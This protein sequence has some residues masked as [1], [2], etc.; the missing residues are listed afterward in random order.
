MGRINDLART[1]TGVFFAATENGLY[2]STDGANWTRFTLTSA[3]GIATSFWDIEVNTTSGLIYAIS[4]STIF[5]STDQGLTWS[6]VTTSGLTGTSIRRL[7][8]APNGNIWV[9]DFSN[10]L[11]RAN[12]ATPTTFNQIST[13]SSAINDFDIGPS[14]QIAIATQ[15]NSVQVST[16]NGVSFNP[17]GAAL[18]TNA[19]T[20]SVVFNSSGVL[21][22]LASD[23]PYRTTNNGTAWTAIKNNITEGSF[24]GFMEVDPSNNL[25]LGNAG[26]GRI[27]T[28]SAANSLLASP[29]WAMAVPPVTDSMLSGL[30][31]S[32]TNWHIAFGSYAVAN[33]QDGGTNWA[34]NSTGIKAFNAGGS[35]ITPRI[36][37]SASN[38]LLMGWSGGG[39]FISID[40]GATWDLLNTPASNTN[41]VLYGFITASDNSIIGYGNGVI[42]STDNAQNWTL[43]NASP[44]HVVLTN[45]GAILYSFSSVNTNTTLQRST[46]NGANWTTLALTGLPGSFTIR[47]LIGNATTLYLLINNGIYTVNT[48]TGACTLI[49]TVP[50]SPNDLVVTGP[51]GAT[52]LAVAGNSTSVAI[53]SNGGSTWVTRSAPS[54]VTRI[55]AAD[56]NNIYGQSSTVG[57]FFVSNNAGTTWTTTQLGDATG[58]ATDAIFSSQGFAYLA[59]SNMAVQK[60]NTV[61]VAPKAPTNLMELSKGPTGSY[62]VWDDN[63]GTEESYEVEK[64]VGNNTSYALAFTLGSFQ[65]IQNKISTFVSADIGATTYVR[66]RATNDAGNSAYSNEITIAPFGNGCSPPAGDFIPNNRSWTATAV[67]DPGFTATNSGPFTSS[68]AAIT[69]T[70]NGNLTSALVSNLRLGMG[71]NGQGPNN[72]TVTLNERCGQATIVNS[73]VGTG[74]INNGNSTWNPAT[75]TLTIKWQTSFNSLAFKGTTTYVLNASDPI[76]A[77]TTLTASIYSNTEVFLSWFTSSFA[78]SYDLERSTTSGSGFALVGTINYPSTSF[79]DG[80]LTAGQTY[81]YR[82]RSKN[83]AGSSANSAEV[84]VTPTTST[85]F[86]PL[87]NAISQNFEGQQGASW[88]D[89]DN[90]GDDDIAIPAFT[91]STNEFI[92]P[93]FYQNQGNNVFVRFTP[94]SLIPENTATSRGVGI[95]DYDN[96]NDLDVIIGR[97]G[98]GTVASALLLTNNGNWNFTK[99]SLDQTAPTG[100]GVAFRGFAVSDYDQD[101]FADV[102]LGSVDGSGLSPFLPSLQ[103]KNNGGT[104]ISR[105]TTGTFATDLNSA[106]T[107]L[108]GDYDNDGD[109]DI[110]MVNRLNPPDVNKLFKNNGDG[111]FSLVTGLVFDSDPATQTRAGSWGDIDNDGDLDLFVGLTGATNRLYQNNG[112]GTFT[113]LTSSPVSEVLSATGSAFGDL[114]NDGDLDLVVT[115]FTANGIYINGGTGNFTKSTTQEIFVSPVLSNVGGAFSDFDNDGFLDFY[116]PIT[117]SATASLPNLLC[118]NTNTASPSRNWIEV[119]LKGTISNAAALGARVT[120]TTTSPARTQVR[121]VASATGYGSQ[122]SLTQHFGLGTAT[123]ASQIQVRWPNGGIQTLTNVAANQI[124]TITED[125]AGPSFTLTPANAATGV[126][127]NSTLKIVLSEAG[128][129][130]AGKNI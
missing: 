73:N 75:K 3:N 56:E 124:I 85:V 47:K 4:F 83:A 106:M 68:A 45:V 12:F 62:V 21:F 14:N 66:V 17:P 9:A 110:F 108:P 57:S 78:T 118:K 46:D 89:F 35:T 88:G 29:T 41:R 91:N 128:T 96:D 122:N 5:S 63:T 25:Y 49:T 58:Q 93:Y 87:V 54:I 22:A 6:V 123:T 24:F 39:F 125:L 7:K 97:S 126:A 20:Y 95:F 101:G 117:S 40:D 119:K 31:L 8:I 23:G 104:S 43:Q 82:I 33:T 10:V 15:N 98:A 72:V 67:A 61:I 129:P 42:R 70:L 19:T 76:P 36:F 111:S 99:T 109:Q 16:N 38:R 34:Q 127:L 51:S 37:R 52:L 71:I 94:T 26:F 121:E 32:A 18:A 13:F 120:V 53:S 86:R 30:F 65:A 69:A 11:F 64:S 112:N 84:S 28:V 116:L 107:L 77:A 80:N 130:V 44:S 114:D 50:V 92:A 74:Y 1:S 79:L 103:L 60:S 59:G 48:S 55:W 105:I 2:R 100:G 81:Y 27:Y 90:D 102:F 113:S 115:S